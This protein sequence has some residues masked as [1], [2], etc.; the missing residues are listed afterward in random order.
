MLISVYNRQKD[1]KISK[2]KIKKIVAATI[3]FEGEHCDEVA[4]HFV[5]T[6]EICD[7]HKQF[8]ND[9]SPTDCISLPIDDASETHY[10][11]LGDVF[12]CPETAVRYAALNHCDLMNE[13]TLYVVHGLLHLMG[14]DDI[15]VKDR[16]LMRA[17]EKRHMDHL[18]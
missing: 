7:L 12:V 5:T 17:A 3:A 4:V 9:P 6:D 13:I 8:F 1:V 11:V 14:Y 16:R 15:K 2:A 18:I 10:L